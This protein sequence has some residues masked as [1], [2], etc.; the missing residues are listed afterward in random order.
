MA[1]DFGEN[2]LEITW[3][4]LGIGISGQGNIGPK[5]TVAD[6]ERYTTDLLTQNIDQSEEVVLLGACRHITFE[7]VNMIL[8][9]LSE[10]ENRENAIETRK[11]RV[12]YVK[13]YLCQIEKLDY[14]I[15]LVG[16]DEMQTLLA[17]PDDMPYKPQ[18]G[19]GFSVEDYYREEMFHHIIERHLIW[20]NDEINQIR[21]LEI[22]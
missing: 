22:I 5:I 11:W 10:R 16:F 1:V 7:E 18:S 20:I 19:S 15:G 13:K 14:V 17:T 2:G 3:T 12:L 6:I 9:K 4:G 21:A 8:E